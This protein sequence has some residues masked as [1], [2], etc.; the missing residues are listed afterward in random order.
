MHHAKKR[1]LHWGASKEQHIAAIAAVAK[2]L[3]GGH[4]VRS[5]NWRSA[6]AS[7][8]AERCIGSPTDIRYL[9]GYIGSLG[10]EKLAEFRVAALGEDPWAGG[11]LQRPMQEA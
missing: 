5:G 11:V 10:T 4:N 3:H 1:P 8:I 6:L 9:R 2:E 7:A